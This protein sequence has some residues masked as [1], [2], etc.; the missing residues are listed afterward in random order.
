MATSPGLL[1]ATAV[2]YF[3]CATFSFVTWSFLIAGR[4]ISKIRLLHAQSKC[5]LFQ[6]II[7]I[8]LLSGSISLGFV[9]AYSPF[10]QQ[11]MRDRYPSLFFG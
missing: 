10:L 6:E 8:L 4:R 9:L 2:I 7:G 5:L 11:G 1:D 3:L